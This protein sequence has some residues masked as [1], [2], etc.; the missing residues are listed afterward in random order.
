[1][2]G[3]LI[4]VD[5]HVQEPPDLWAKRLPRTFADRAPHVESTG[6]GSERWVLDEQVLLD[7]NV[8]RAGAF[9]E[10][11]NREPRRWDDVPAAAYRPA[12]RLKAM[13]AAGVDRSVLYPTVAGSAG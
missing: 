11:R 2:A 10:D 7:G 12:D 4:S 9:M 6:D 13:D 5:D 1:M 8:A 3:R